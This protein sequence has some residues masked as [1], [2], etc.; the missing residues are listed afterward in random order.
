MVKNARYVHPRWDKVFIYH[1]LYGGL[2]VSVIKKVAS[3]DTDVA[4]VR[5]SDLEPWKGGERYEV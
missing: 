5:N 3:F 2:K 4:I 1:V